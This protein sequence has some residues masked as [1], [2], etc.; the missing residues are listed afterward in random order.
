[1]PRLRAYAPQ[2]WPHFLALEL[3][4]QLDSLGESTSE[5][6]AI[7]KERFPALLDV[8]MGFTRNGFRR[9]GAQLWVLEGDD[10]KYLGHL[11]LTER[12]D[13]RH[14]TPTLQVT[15]LGIVR[16]G[17]GKNY[18]RLLM[19]KAEQE[20]RERG[21]EVVALEVAGNNRR[22]RDLFKDLGYETIRRTMQK[23]LRAQ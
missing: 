18:G 10:G 1:M 22:A 17:R 8:K 4:T 13:A 16:D 20:A 14:G 11:W 15:T 6:R 12:D 9:P 5:E 3:D 23:R 19:Q 2:D 21:I 7:F